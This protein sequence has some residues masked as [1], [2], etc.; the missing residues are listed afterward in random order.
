MRKPIVRLA[1]VVAVACALTSPAAAQDKG[2]VVAIRAGRL[3]DVDK[4]EVLRDQVIVIRGDRIEAVQ[5]GSS[6]LPAGARVIDLSKFTVVPGLIDCHTHLIGDIQSADVL[7]PLERSEAQEVMSGVRNARATLLAGFTSVRDVGTYRAFVDAALRDAID[8]GTVVGPRME[9]AGAYVTVSTGAGE[10]VEGTLVNDGIL[11]RGETSTEAIAEKARY[12][13]AVMA[14]RLRG[15]HATQDEI[16]AVNV[17]TIHPLHRLMET[18]VLPGLPAARQLGV[19]WH[20]TR[21]PV[22]D[23]EYEMDLRGVVTQWVV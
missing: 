10:L 3:V 2:Q 15:L 9:V 18:L 22:I 8:D 14:E 1:A 21:P 12:V 4:G 19:T 11:R 23:I 5:P 16:T 20:Y 13:C 17:Y 7:L 6:K